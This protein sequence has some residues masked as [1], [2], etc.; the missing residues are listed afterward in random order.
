MRCNL[1]LFV[2]FFVLFSASAQA[3]EPSPPSQ[4]LPLL[5]RSIFEKPYMIYG[6]EIGGWEIDGGNAILNGLCR[7]KIADAKIRVIRWGNWT[8]F[9]DMKQKGSEPRQTLAQFNLVIDGIRSMG[10]YPL[11]KLP[12]IW[13]MQCGTRIDAWNLAWLKEIIKNAGSRVQLYEFASEPNNYCRWDAD[14][15]AKNWAAT[16]PAL[17]RYARLLGFEIYVG[18]PAWSNS[19]HSDLAR[20]A[21]FLKAVRENYVENRS[22]DELPDFIS[23][24][25]T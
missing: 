10:A 21:V 25:T 17:K 20:L 3:Q 4:S 15:Y 12:P 9:E 1:F 22:R 5:D 18:G 16:V 14:T 8:K 19:N 11:I 23:T 2:C 6:S 7:Q 24:H 13:N